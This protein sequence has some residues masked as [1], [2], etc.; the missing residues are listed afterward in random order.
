MLLFAA[1]LVPAALAAGITITSGQT[2]YY[3]ALG[4]TAAISLSV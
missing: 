4:Q 2:D 3:F 1:L